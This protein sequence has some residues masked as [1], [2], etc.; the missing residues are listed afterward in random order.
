MDSK[1]LISEM[2]RGFLQLLVLSCCAETEIHGYGLIKKI[3][4][5]GYA[6]EENSLYPLLRRLAEKNF[7]ETSWQI[8]NDRPKKV[9]KI[10]EGGR[11]VL[12]EL[13]NIRE[14]QNEILRK[15]W[16]GDEDE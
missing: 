13:V 3:N 4:G 16:G 1:S 2:N 12:G 6:I 5:L 9:Y 7:L 14:N 11:V 8:E 10:T 15:V